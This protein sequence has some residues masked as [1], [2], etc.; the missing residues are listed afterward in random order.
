MKITRVIYTAKPDYVEINKK[1]IETVMKAVRALNSPDLKY[2]TFLQE[3]GT[4]FMHLAFTT[5]QEANDLLTNLPE[6]KF[7]TSELRAKGIENPPKTEHL[8]L[9]ASGYDIF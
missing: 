7:F 2:A 8:S 5:N 9:V 1:N 3:D 6:F 4:T